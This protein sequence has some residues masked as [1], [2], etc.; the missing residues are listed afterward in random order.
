MP[1][2]RAHGVIRLG[3]KS[4]RFEKRGLVVYLLILLAI[5]V[6][7]S[8]SLLIG[9]YAI[10]FEEVIA[11][12]TGKA[13]DRLAA[14][15]IIDVRLARIVAGILVGA[16]LGCSGA[17]FQTLSGNPLGSPDII[18]FTKGAAT[19][20]LI[21]IVLFSG[22]PLLI[23]LGAI[24]G[25]LATAILVFGLSWRGGA[26]GLRLVLVGIG[27]GATL[28]ALN[29]LLVVKA[30]LANAELAIHWMAGSLNASLWPEVMATGLVCALLLLLVLSQYRAL[31]LLPFGDNI[32]TGLGVRT[33]R[34][35]LIC[36]FAGVMLMAM[37]TALAGPIS[38]VALVAPHLV[39]RL[40][41]TSG[42][43]LIGAALTGSLLVL[44][45]DLIARRLFA[46]NELAI[47]I[48]TGSLGGLYLVVLLA[49]EWRRR[50][51]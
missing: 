38:F 13:K 21:V 51:V 7:A 35:R 19:G 9:D 32:A 24:A 42:I 43:A 30:P 16:A 31:S 4:L 27:V 39:K 45:C 29:G 15:F 34:S 26:P 3:K 36:M 2:S 10:S 23:S 48:V 33:E 37:A 5:L 12:F 25:G 41:G 8:A 18:G 1:P 28:G 50:T 6:L 49:F 46:P 11:S 17:V 40:S 22:S 44:S 20:A 47:G 14:Y